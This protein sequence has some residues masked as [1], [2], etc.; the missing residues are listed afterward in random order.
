[1]NDNLPAIDQ[2]GRVRLWDEKFNC[3]ADE[4]ANPGDKLGDVIN[5][6]FQQL[7]LA[8]DSA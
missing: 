6:A 2:R 1:M 7:D 4:R 5:R 8:G 3:L